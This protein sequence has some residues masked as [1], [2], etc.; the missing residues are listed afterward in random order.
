MFFLRPTKSVS[1]IIDIDEQLLKEMKVKAILLDIDNTLSLHGK[2]E[3]LEGVIEWLKNLKRLGYSLFIISNNKL[4]RVQMFANKL[5]IEF[6]AMAKKP[7]KSGFNAAKN[8]LKL[9]PS[10]ILVVGDQIFTDILGA[11]LSNMKSVLL[12]PV[13]TNENKFI[14]FKRILERPIRSRYK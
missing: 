5:D 4:K 13:D 6:I 2:E 12:E 1:K 10:E 7:F 3:P 9:E 11:N 14:K 8:I